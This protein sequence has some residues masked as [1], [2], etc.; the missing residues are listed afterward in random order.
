MVS[1]L[2]TDSADIVAD[3]LRQVH[4]LSCQT[5]EQSVVAEAHAVRYG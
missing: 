5:I 4:L 3:R 1:E 2:R